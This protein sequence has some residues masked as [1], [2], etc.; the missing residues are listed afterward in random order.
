VKVEPL[1]HIGNPLIVM[2]NGCIYSWWCPDVE[3]CLCDE[4][5]FLSTFPNRY[6]RRSPS[7][8]RLR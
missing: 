4:L 1:P 2:R 7:S 3:N 8:I 6:T 5:L